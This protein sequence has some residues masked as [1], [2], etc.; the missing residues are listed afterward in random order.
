MRGSTGD[1]T[2]VTVHAE[3]FIDQQH[4]GCLAQPLA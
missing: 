1:L 4:I 2:V 3:R